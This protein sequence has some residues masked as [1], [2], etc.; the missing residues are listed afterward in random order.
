MSHSWINHHAWFSRRHVLLASGPAFG[1]ALPQRRRAPI[2]QSTESAMTRLQ[3]LLAQSPRGRFGIDTLQLMIG[4]PWVRYTVLPWQDNL[5][6]D[7]DWQG[8]ARVLLGQQYGVGTETWR[9]QVAE[10][11]YGRPRLAAAMDQGLYQTLV[12]MAKN[13]KLRLTQCEPLLTA[14]INRHHKSLKGKEFALLLIEAEHTTCVFWRSGWR[15]SVTLPFALNPRPDGEALAALVRDASMLV[16]DFM[17]RQVY[18]VSS[19]I[20][21]SGLSAEGMT[22]HT[23]GGVHP[24]FAWPA[25]WR[26]AA[27]PVL[28]GPA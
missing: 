25:D 2:E 18:V 15:A 21:L 4:A 27:E 1:K 13:Q 17:P 6:R 5:K 22:L 10:G 14:A 12:D 28:A 3:Q 23:L 19:D 24:R 7:A 16:S 8:Y 9:V 20:Q 11:V 26:E